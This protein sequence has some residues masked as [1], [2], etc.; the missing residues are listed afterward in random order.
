VVVSKL[1]LM[2]QG[3]NTS[4]WTVDQ[5]SALWEALPVVSKLS[6]IEQA[7]H[8]LQCTVDQV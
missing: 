4:Q 3:R 8:T 7:R 5:V 1:S 2:E 6:L